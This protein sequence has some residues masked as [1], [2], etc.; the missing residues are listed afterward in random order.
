MP[1]WLLR[2]I[3]GK[4]TKTRTEEIKNEYRDRKRTRE[5]EMEWYVKRNEKRARGK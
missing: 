2:T 4:I 3:G 1:E 5:P